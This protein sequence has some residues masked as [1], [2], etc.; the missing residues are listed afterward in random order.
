MPQI[1]AH[2]RGWAARILV[3]GTLLLFFDLGL[4]GTLVMSP[5]NDEPAHVL[6]GYILR[7]TGSLQYQTGHAPLSHR[8]IGLLL[9]GE[10]SLPEVEQLPSWPD[11]ERLVLASELMWDSGLD[12]DR[13]LFLARLPVLLMGILLGG[14]I[15]SWALS[16]HGRSAMAVAMVLFA[17][18]PN[19]LAAASLATTDFVTVVTYFATI[20]AWWRAWRFGSWK[21]WLATAV[22]LGLAL[23]AKLTA[24]LLLPVLFLLTFLFLGK[25]KSFWRP[26]AAWLALLPLAALVLWIVYGLQID[27]MPGFQVPLP[28]AAYLVSWQTVMDHVERGHQ[29][30]FLG[31]LSGDGWWSYF[32]ITYLIKTPL[33][34]LILLLTGLGVIV[35]RRELWRTA[36]F[37]LLPVAALFAAAMTSRLNIGYRHILP[38]T[39]FLIVIASTAVLLLRR[40]KVTQVALILALLWYVAAAIRQNPHFLAY[41]NELVG[42]TDQGYRYLGDSNLDWGQDLKLLADEI[43][44]EGGDWIVSYA[45]SADPTY[46]GIDS[47]A[48]ID[49]ESGEL[50]F[51]PA[52]PQPGHYA[53]SANHLQGI[54][55][56]ADMFDWFRK[57]IT[58]QNLG[59]AIL[60]YD[61]LEQSQ[62]AWIAHCS[63]PAPLLS[64]V[65]AE[66]ILGMSGLRHIWFDCAQSWV[67][68]AGDEP[69][70]YIV[71]QADN[72]W[73]TEYMSAESAARLQHVYRHRAT[74]VSPSYDVYYWQG[75]SLEPDAEKTLTGAIVGGQTQS[76]PYQ[77]GPPAT[78]DGYQVG[79][80]AWVNFWRVEATPDQPISLRAHLYSE[81]NPTPLVDDALGYPGELW[82]AQDTIWQR[83]WFSSMDDASYL[84]TGIYN[85]LTLD[86]IGEM[87]R[88]PANRPAN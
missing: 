51:A 50:P 77:V 60:I 83:H 23:A 72:L 41:F 81:G 31:E 66:K 1:D 44:S 6:R 28:A 16:W 17:A 55:K 39:P 20:Y 62:G 38:M 80:D 29:A 67:L 57:Q 7:S 59:G 48:L 64:D 22:F 30:F 69:G 18:S 3:I 52:N 13:A 26:F 85:Y 56:D 88:L 9:S 5:T 36:V 71:P 24:V 74:A 45:G 70:W 35:S 87:V 79:T 53:I 73:P 14:L 46:Y 61:V 86:V 37:L 19:L 32:P 12:V 11:G 63:D 40:W 4:R 68:P 27:R 21:W 78:L 76:L 33:V 15:G 43:K 82:R 8:L 58:V 47:A 75:D 65:E 54:L 2:L 42:G 84:E 25:G 49:D 34:T 10:P